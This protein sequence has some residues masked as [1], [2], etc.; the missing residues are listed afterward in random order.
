MELSNLKMNP[1]EK[2]KYFNQR[3]L[4]LKNRIPTD[5]IPVESLIVAYYTKYLH[6]NI[7]I[8]VKRSK[9][10]TSLEA[11]EEASQIKKD[12][13]SLKDNLSNEVEISPSS[14]KKIEILTRPPQTKTQSKTSDLE[15]LQK[16]IQKLSNQFTDLRRSA[17]ESSSSKGSYK[18]P[19]RKPFPPN[20]KNPIPKGLNFEALQ[21]ALQTIP[22]AHDNLVPPKNYEDV[23][24]E[25][26]AEEEDSS[27]NV[28][29]HF[30]DNIFQANFETVHP[31]NTKRKMLSKTSSEISTNVPLK[32]LKQDETKQNLAAPF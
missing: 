11:F 21:Y 12:I 8:W 24:E 2:V 14:K 16:V 25:E 27:P 18:T 5:S 4:M 6:H 30:F 9:K 1:K 20:W 32:Q 15:S 10:S 13:L 3:F 22:E 17:E 19:F 7:A 29:G 28:F 23:A 26:I 31:Y